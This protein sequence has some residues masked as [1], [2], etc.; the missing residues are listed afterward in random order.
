MKKLYWVIFGKY[1]KFEKPK[2]SYLLKKA[3]LLSIISSKCNN[4]YERIFT[5]EDSIQILKV[6]GL[7]QNI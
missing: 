1:R 2:I 3:L 5:E 6:F 4:G 7:I